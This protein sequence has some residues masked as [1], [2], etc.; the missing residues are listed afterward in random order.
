MTGT[1]ATGIGEGWPRSG[2]FAS[3]HASHDNSYTIR[4]H[5]H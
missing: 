5:R 1:A 4:V 3:N 2:L